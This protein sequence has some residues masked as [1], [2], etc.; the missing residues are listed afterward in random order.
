M[1]K[2]PRVSSINTVRALERLGFV[3]VRQKGSHLILKKQLSSQEVQIKNKQELGC[4]V[5]MQ[6]KTLATGTLKSILN[7]AEVSIEDFVKSL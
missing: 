7:Q 4:V 5:P 3:P 2:L 1:P 6:R